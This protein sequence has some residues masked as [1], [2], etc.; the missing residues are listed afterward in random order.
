MAAAEPAA[1]GGSIGARLSIGII[2]AGVS[3][4]AAARQ[5]LLHYGGKAQI[6]VFDAQEPLF[7][8]KNKKRNTWQHFPWEAAK[9]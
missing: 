8:K 5:A 9:K 3:G 2:G 6:V 1:R 7:L 4:L